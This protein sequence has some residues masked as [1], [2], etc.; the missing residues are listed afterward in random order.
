MAVTLKSKNDK[1][2]NLTYSDD[3]EA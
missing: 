2:V 3:I 1:Y